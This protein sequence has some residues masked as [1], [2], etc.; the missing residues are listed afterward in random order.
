[1]EGFAET[2]CYATACLKKLGVIL[3]LNN[4][5]EARR[6]LTS[7]PL[8]D[9][10]K[11]RVCIDDANLLED[12]LVWSDIRHEVDEVQGRLRVELGNGNTLEVQLNNLPE[13]MLFYIVIKL[14]NN[15]SD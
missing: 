14:L 6:E 2:S 11:Y 9:H 15:R 12:V 10:S 8:V 1:M 7:D 3:N 13:P 4:V 5:P